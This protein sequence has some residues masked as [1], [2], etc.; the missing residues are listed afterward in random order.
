M[1]GPYG[2]GPGGHGYFDN[3]GNPLF[4]GKST[5]GS[6]SA[7]TSSGMTVDSAGDERE[8]DTETEGEGMSDVAM[9][10]EMGDRSEMGLSDD[11]GLEAERIVERLEQGEGRGKVLGGPDENGSGKFYFEEKK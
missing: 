8:V 3:Q 4:R 6:A 9:P 11:G 7:T 2:G 1:G 5:V 10:S